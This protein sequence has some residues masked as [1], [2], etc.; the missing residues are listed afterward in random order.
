MNIQIE[1]VEK[2][3]PKM[4]GYIKRIHNDFS[5]TVF[6]EKDFATDFNK[7]RLNEAIEKYI[8]KHSVIDVDEKYYGI[9]DNARFKFTKQDFEVMMWY[10]IRAEKKITKLILK[11]Q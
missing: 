5:C 4:K 10:G 3:N 2:E 11:E 6:H 9:W 1:Y 8:Q 7:T